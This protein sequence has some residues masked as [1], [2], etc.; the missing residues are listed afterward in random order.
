MVQS[1]KKAF[2]EVYFQST[3]LYCTL[4]HTETSGVPTLP[5][6]S[7]VLTHTFPLPCEGS[8]SDKTNLHCGDCDPRRSVWREK[9][10]AAATTGQRTVNTEDCS[11]RRLLS[12][13]ISPL[14]TWVRMVNCK[15]NLCINCKSV[16][17]QRNT[18]KARTGLSS[19]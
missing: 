3:H 7:I 15:R 2:A 17:C 5:S 1:L 16:S 4:Y 19:N 6:A 9:T 10:D 8:Q 13:V 12:S 14:R 11:V 18:A